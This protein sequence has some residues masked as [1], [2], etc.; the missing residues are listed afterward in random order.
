MRQGLA[1]WW[2]SPRAAGALRRLV[3]RLRQARYDV[4]IDAQGLLRSALLARLSGAPLRIGFANA[5]EGAPLCYTHAVR[6]P[7]APQVAV[8]RMRALLGPLGVP[9]TGPADA[10][11]PVSPAAASAISRRIGTAPYTVLVPGARWDTKRWSEE[12]FADIARRLAADGRRVFLAGSPDERALCERVAL[13]AAGPQDAVVSLAGR[14]SL[15]EMVALLAGAELVV[16]N[17]SGPLH[18]AVALGRPTVSVYGPT[19]PNFVGPYGQLDRV[20]RFPVHCHPCRLKTCDH[21][22]CMKG[23]T[24]ELVWEKVA[25]QPAHSAASDAS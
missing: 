4:V 21:H 22:S 1:A 6:L 18:V 12:G 25:A 8:V 24:V 17:D 7:R 2:R 23:V 9:T 14:T 5:R 15:A 11:V 16:G 19:D 13:L 10:C 20:V 3:G